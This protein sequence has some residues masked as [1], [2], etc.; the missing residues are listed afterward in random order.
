MNPEFIRN[1]FEYELYASLIDTILEPAEH[2][3]YACPM[4]DILVTLERVFN[5]KIDPTALFWALID[6]EVPLIY[7]DDEYYFC[8][9]IRT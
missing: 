8:V 6:S 4:Y 5:V 7:R 1:T 9:K 3:A 2:S